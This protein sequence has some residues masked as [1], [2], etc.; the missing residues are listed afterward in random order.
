[1]FVSARV[2]VCVYV[3]VS[4]FVCVISKWHKF[5]LPA[6]F[7]FFFF[8]CSQVT[9]ILQLQPPKLT[10]VLQCT[11]YLSIHPSMCVCARLPVCVCV[12]AVYSYIN[13]VVSVTA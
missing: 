4:L 9:T 11:Q 3:Y 7:F 13:G 6:P 12:Y 1:M 5:K 8:F 2:D 10:C